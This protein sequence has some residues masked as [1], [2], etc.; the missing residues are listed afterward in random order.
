M[1]GRWRLPGRCHIADG[2]GVEELNE[3]LVD[4]VAETVTD[5]AEQAGLL[6]EQLGGVRRVAGQRKHQVHFGFQDAA[7]AVAG[8][9]VSRRCFAS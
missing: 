2:C 9:P 8:R 4:I 3:F 1:P 6:I 7:D 5:V